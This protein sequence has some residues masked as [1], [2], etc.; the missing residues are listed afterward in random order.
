MEEMTAEEQKKEESEYNADS[1]K[2]LKGVVK[3]TAPTS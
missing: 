2:V 3:S 1:I